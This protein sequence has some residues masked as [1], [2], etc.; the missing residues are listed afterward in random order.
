M[1]DGYDV[2]D[3]VRA[4]LAAQPA[5]IA[6]EP[7]DENGFRRGVFLCALNQRIQYFTIQRLQVYGL[8][9]VEMPAFREKGSEVCTIR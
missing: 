2:I 6:V 8:V 3:A 7:E 9:V 4:V 5:H 1:L